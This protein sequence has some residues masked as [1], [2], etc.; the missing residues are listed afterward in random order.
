VGTD[1]VYETSPHLTDFNV[2]RVLRCYD[3]Y[4]TMKPRFE[5]RTG[6]RM[7]RQSYIRAQ[8]DYVVA[9]A[10]RT[11]RVDLDHMW[12][13]QADVR[14]GA[15]VEEYGQFDTISDERR[16]DLREQAEKWDDLL[17]KKN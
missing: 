11:G 7:T 16:Q 14:A 4:C 12:G 3:A 5:L 1:P 13:V 17:E 2:W 6:L 15:W 10:K 8:V 9:R